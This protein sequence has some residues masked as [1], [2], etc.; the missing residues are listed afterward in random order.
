MA[1]HGSFVWFELMTPDSAAADRF[2]AAVMGWTIT[3]SGMPGIDYRIAAAGSVPVGGLMAPPTDECPTVLPGWMAYISTDDVDRTAADAAA[4]GGRILREPFD[5]PGIGRAATLADPHGAAFHVFRG[6][7]ERPS[8]FAMDVPGLVGWSELHAGNLTEA[9][10]FYTRL[11]GW[12]KAEAHD[13]GPLGPYQVF[14]H[15]G[16]PTCG[17]M[18]AAQPQVPKPVWNFYVNVDDIDAA[19]DRTARAGGRLIMEPQE[20]P[21]GAYILHALDPQGTPF[22][23]LGPPR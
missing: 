23:L 2:Y 14:N 4:A 17:M 20:V 5:M 1:H 7:D 6:I 16:S 15:R 8:P 11:F 9:E 18:T 12:E 22:A 21:G 3:D 19:A 10:R 13:I